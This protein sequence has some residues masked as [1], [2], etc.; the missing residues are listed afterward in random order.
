LASQWDEAGMQRVSIGSGMNA[1]GVARKTQLRRHRWL[2]TTPQVEI[3]WTKLE[4]G[5]GFAEVV[6]VSM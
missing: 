2:V 4:L 5:D 6:D 1:R 3:W